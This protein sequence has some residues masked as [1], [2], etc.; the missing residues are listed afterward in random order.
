M[1]TAQLEQSGLVVF[2]A[3]EHQLLAEDRDTLRLL[4][5]QLAAADRMPVAPQQFSHR[6]SGANLTQQTVLVLG[7]HGAPPCA[8]VF[9]YV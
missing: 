2:S 9:V 4:G 8:A 7:E 6:C 1:G 5:E 3:I